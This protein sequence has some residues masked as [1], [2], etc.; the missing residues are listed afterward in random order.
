MKEKSN[1]YLLF[2]CFLR[3]R[4]GSLSALI[5]SD[6]AEGITSILALRFC[7]VNLTVTRMPFHSSVAL[8]IS[9]PTFFGD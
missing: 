6:D 7:T 4:G 9:S 5:T 8:A 2:F 3:S 1:E